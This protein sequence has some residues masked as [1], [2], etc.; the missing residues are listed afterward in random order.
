MQH[1]IVEVTPTVSSGAAYTANDQVGGLMTLTGA[2]PA[3]SD[4]AVLRQISVV[5]K[6]KQSAALNVLLF[7]AQPTV[8]SSDNAACDVADAELAGKCLGH[9]AIAAG[10][11]VALSAGSVAA[12]QVTVPVKADSSAT[13]YALAMTT[14]TPTYASTSDL[15]FRFHFTW[16]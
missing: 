1:H 3:S 16:D 13:L 6:G 8:A 14:G 7:D 2:V 11:Y 4:G 10:D 15:V 12:K 9:V 5:D